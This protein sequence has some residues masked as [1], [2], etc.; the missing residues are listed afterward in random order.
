MVHFV[1]VMKF[2]IELFSIFFKGH[3]MFRIFK[4]NQNIS[5]KNIF[6]LYRES[7]LCD[8]WLENNEMLSIGIFFHFFFIFFQILQ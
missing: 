7:F 2:W 4:L 3:S 1:Y 8:E 6:L 5:T